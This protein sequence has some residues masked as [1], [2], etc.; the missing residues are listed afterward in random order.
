[1]LI[2]KVTTKDANIGRL[3]GEGCEGATVDR[4]GAIRRALHCGHLRSSKVVWLV[5]FKNA[6][7]IRHGDLFISLKIDISCI[8]GL[9]LIF[10]FHLKI[11][12][13]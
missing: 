3:R 13:G 8:I 10:D 1:M 6:L 9:A 12:D 11:P 7:T 4:F 2:H 5:Q